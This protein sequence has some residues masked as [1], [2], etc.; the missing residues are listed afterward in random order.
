MPHR[1]RLAFV[2]AALAVPATSPGCAGEHGAKL[3]LRYHPPAGASYHYTFEQ[4]SA[5]KVASGPMAQ[6]PEQ[7]FTMRMFFRQAVTGPTSGGVGVT[8]TF[9]STRVE[10]PT[11]APGALGPAL[12]RMRGM[13]STLVYDDRMNI[14]H[15]EFANAAGPLSPI[16]EQIGRN[17]KGMAYPLPEKPVG[18]GDSWTAHTQ[19]PLEQVAGAHTALNATTT[20]TVK[21]LNTG[22]ADT[23]VLLGVETRFP[24]DPIQVTQEGHQR[25]VK[26]SGSSTG[27]LL[28]SLTKGA[29]VRLSMEGKVAVNVSGDP[30][31]SDA[32][33]LSVRQATTLQLNGAQ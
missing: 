20:L 3:T 26:M 29:A 1:R 25:T 30:A 32:V 12:E 5:M 21:Q 14:V 4:H 16:T 10:S 2:A 31:G 15:A 6:M 24:G 7:Q 17:I 22:G 19:L 13:T 33:D 27:E 8:V 23:T 9:D 18:V 11:M 28:F